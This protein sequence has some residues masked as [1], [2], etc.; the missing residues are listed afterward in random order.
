MPNTVT[1]LVTVVTKSYSTK[2]KTNTEN[3]QAIWRAELV[4]LTSDEGVKR[5]P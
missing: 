1:E 5:F 4:S 3:A 2:K